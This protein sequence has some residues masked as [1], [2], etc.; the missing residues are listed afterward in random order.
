MP[1]C[2]V[3]AVETIQKNTKTNYGNHDYALLIPQPLLHE[4]VLVVRCACKICKKEAVGRVDQ[5]P[6]MLRALLIAVLSI[7]LVAAKMNS[8]SS[9]KSGSDSIE[10][11]LAP[12]LDVLFA[13]VDKNSDGKLS[14][15]E[16]Q[17]MID[18]LGLKLITV[19]TP[20]HPHTQHTQHVLFSPQ[21]F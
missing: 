5:L 18:D 20:T 12:I 17:G 6:R 19:S 11:A 16:A 15:A 4:T 8:T 2:E 21:R 10:A 14:T 9:T 13:Q 1:T 3:L 7:E